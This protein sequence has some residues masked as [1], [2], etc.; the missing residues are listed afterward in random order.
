MAD[1]NDERLCHFQSFYISIKI[2]NHRLHYSQL[3]NVHFFFCSS[4]PATHTHT[5]LKAQFSRT[6]SF[7]TSGRHFLL[8]ISSKEKI[9]LER[10]F[11]FFFFRTTVTR[12][13][14][15]ER[16]SVRA[17]TRGNESLIRNACRLLF[18]L[19]PIFFLS[20]SNVECIFTLR[21]SAHI[22]SGD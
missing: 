11:F 20:S 7:K 8:I 19:K 14:E 13:R 18:P 5:H 6:L 9:S 2:Q 12:E 10:D 3:T 17:H 1:V 21:F 22:D 4:N 15:R 16:E